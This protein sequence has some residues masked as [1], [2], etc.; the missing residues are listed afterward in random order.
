MKYDAINS[1]LDFTPGE[2]KIVLKGI[3]S[4]DVKYDP[5]TGII[6]VNGNDLA[7]LDGK[8]AIKLDD[9]FEFM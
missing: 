7:A 3:S 9:D 2:D 6:S 8:P 4:S 5:A 1:I